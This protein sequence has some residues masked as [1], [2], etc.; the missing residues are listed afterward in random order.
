MA[1]AARERPVV[2]AAAGPASARL[3]LV[4][5]ARQ[6]LTYLAPHAVR[7]PLKVVRPFALPDGGALVQV[8]LN[9]PGL[10][11]GDH[12]D[13]SIVVEPGARAVV[14]SPSATKIHQMPDG[15]SA[16]QSVRL[17]VE[18][19]ACLQY[20]PPLNIPFPEAELRQCVSVDLAAGSRFGIVE[21]WAMG[22][23]ERGEHLR[24]RRLSSRTRVTVEGAPVYRDALELAPADA[25]PHGWGLLEGRRYV[26]SGYWQG[27]SIAV[28]EAFVGKDLEA[29]AVFGAVEPGGHYFRGLFL[30]SLAMQRAIAEVEQAVAGSWVLPA[31]SLRPFRC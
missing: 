4:F 27:P 31:I 23:V 8:L 5:R 20:L 6:G 17:R 13:I 2:E 24:F 9:G 28:P 15:G 7:S 22:R 12:Y 18:S 1:P 19:G 26:V 3:E 10:F 11:A 16:T 25:R 30:D 14:M 29:L 21:A